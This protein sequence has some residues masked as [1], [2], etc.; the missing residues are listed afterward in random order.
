MNQIIESIIYI[1]LASAVA[2][3]A[4]K[5]K[6][7]SL[8]GSIAAFLTA[9]VHL[10]AGYTFAFYLLTFFFT[11]SFLT[12]VGKEQKKKLEAKYIEESQRSAEQVCSN[13]IIASLCCVILLLLNSPKGRDACFD[14]S[15]FQAFL[16]AIVPGFYSC[17]TGDTWSSEIGILNKHQ[18]ISIVTFKRV[19]AGTNGGVSSLGS[20][21]GFLGSFMI[22]ILTAVLISYEC[23]FY[24]SLFILITM[25]V[26]GCGV[27]GNILDSVLGATLQYSGWDE[28]RKCVVRQPGENVKH[29]SGKNILSN[30][31][32]NFIT[33]TV[34]GIICAILLVYVRKLYI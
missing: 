19:P 23:A 29:I 14:Y 34:S 11:S 25:I 17:T 31:M 6:S 3:F 4:Y 33:S 5:K 21:I 7:L 15:Q 12:K 26:T 13:S 24:P 22:G 8:S 28:E 20:L 18:P 32:I 9:I 30:S 2:L 10:F 27:I 1:S 16:Y